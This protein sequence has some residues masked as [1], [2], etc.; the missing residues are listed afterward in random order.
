MLKRLLVVGLVV[1]ALAVPQPT[2][3]A[4]YLSGGFSFSSINFGYQSLFPLAGN[5]DLLATF[6]GATSLDFSDTGSLTPGV[7]GTFRVDDV[8]G[9]F[10]VLAGETGL[11]K[12]FS[13]SGPGTTNYPYPP[14]TSFELISAALFSFDLE[15]VVVQ[16]QLS[17][18][19]VLTGTGMLHMD[20]FEDTL[21][22][23]VFSANQAGGT[24]SYSGSNEAGIVPEPGS[25]LLLG[26]GLIG[27]A[28][29]VRRRM[30]K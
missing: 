12:D 18:T 29:A 25:M 22:T 16:L 6:M 15:S 3:A 7:A 23:F 10:N 1:G 24:F 17:S 27:L 5:G 28:G 26:S 13:F 11:I 8:A 14:I 4:P 20:G 21:G 30:K 9:D 2:Q 19:V